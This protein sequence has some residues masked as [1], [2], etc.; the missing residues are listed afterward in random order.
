MN[1]AEVPGPIFHSPVDESD[2]LLHDVKVDLVICIPHV[3]FSPRYRGL[4][5]ASCAHIRVERRGDIGS[6]KQFRQEG[7][8]ED[9]VAEGVW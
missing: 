8:R 9:D 1:Q 6:G 3:R 5:D 2:H 4:E 7:G